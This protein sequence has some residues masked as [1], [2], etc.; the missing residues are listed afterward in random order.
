MGEG[1]TLHS[2]KS[3]H[4]KPGVN[5]GDTIIFSREK[6]K[7]KKTGQIFLIRVNLV[8]TS[9]SI[10]LKNVDTAAVLLLQLQGSVLCVGGL[11]ISNYLLEMGNRIDTNF[12]LLSKMH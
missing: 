4:R 10:K 9:C 2:R 8:Q 11:H 12:L 3:V 5:L 7:E 6:K 1:T